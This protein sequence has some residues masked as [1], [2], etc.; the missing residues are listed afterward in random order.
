MNTCF[1]DGILDQ[2]YLQCSNDDSFSESQPRTHQVSFQHPL[3]PPQPQ[4]YPLPISQQRLPNAT[5]KPQTFQQLNQKLQQL[6]QRLPLHQLMLRQQ[7][8]DIVSGNSNV[9]N[10]YKHTSTPYND[11]TNFN[12]T[13]NN[14]NFK[15]NLGDRLTVSNTK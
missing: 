11:Y 1:S 5:Q 12:K 9:N 15:E 10:C 13:L 6:N 7:Y 14:K 8:N 2:K 4:Q 3:T